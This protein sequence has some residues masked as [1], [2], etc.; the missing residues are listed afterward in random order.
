MCED[1]SG[2]ECTSTTN[3]IRSA[4]PAAAMITNN[5]PPAPKTLPATETSSSK[6]YTI[7]CPQ[8]QHYDISLQR[9]LADAASSVPSSDKNA[10]KLSSICFSNPD[11]MRNIL[12]D[13]TIPPPILSSGPPPS[14]G[15][16][17]IGIQGETPQCV[18]AYHWDE[19]KQK[20]V[21]N[22]VFGP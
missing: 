14:G 20:C 11:C 8:G 15:L 6:Q 4:R 12:P 10:L 5:Y 9:C 21:A 7:P 19:P 2:S 17:K 1:T 16:P 13:L 22:P 18:P 3:V